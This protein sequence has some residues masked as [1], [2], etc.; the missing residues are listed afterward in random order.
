MKQTNKHYFAL[1][2]VAFVTF[3]NSCNK[4][5]DIEPQF[6][7]YLSFASVEEYNTTLSKVLEMSE[8]ERLAWEK[9]QGFTSFVTV[10][11]EVYETV[12][13]KGLTLEQLQQ[14][15][16]PLS[17]YMLLKKDE[18]GDYVL[19]NIAYT[20]EDFYLTNSMR[21]VQIESEYYKFFSD[22]YIYTKHYHVLDSINNES[23]I[24]DEYKN[25]INVVKT[26]KI[27]I[28]DNE[29][30][31]DRCSDNLKHVERKTNGRNRTKI[32]VEIETQT[33][34]NNLNI[35]SDSY[36]V[37]CL[38]RA[39]LRTG[40]IWFHAK[41]TLSCAVRADVLV[42]YPDRPRGFVF[43][44]YECGKNDYS[45]GMTWIN[46]TRYS[47]KSDLPKFDYIYAWGKSPNTDQ[48]WIHCN[49]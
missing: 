19:E 35:G 42:P 6:E 39:Y 38:V 46:W 16:E 48:A 23:D 22:F 30:K 37:Y 49:F 32:T 28:S 14:E 40:G 45:I 11:N 25:N 29:L 44:Y 4:Q 2:A 13:E 18:Y 1:I 7:K 41:R 21:I 8:E 5:T 12:A 9:Q 10:S 15:V 33:E 3:F 47:K 17:E 31:F 26:N 24:T 43:T 27:I 34:L 36:R 20:K